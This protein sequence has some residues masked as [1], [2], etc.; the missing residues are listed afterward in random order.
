MPV[1]TIANTKGGAGK[2]TA[3]V[4][5][6][7]ELAKR[8]HVVTLFDSDPQKWMTQWFEAAKPE[9]RISLI[10]HVTPALLDG[11]LREIRAMNEFA[12]IDLPGHR[13]HMTA[14]A[15]GHSD[16]V[17]IPVQGSTM[18][19]IGATNIIDLLATI[20]R[21]TGH[22]IAHSVL[23]TRVNPAVTTRSLMAIKALL[24]ERGVDV[25]ATPVVERSAF[26]EMFDFG[27]STYALDGQ[28]V[29]NLDKAQVNAQ[30]LCDEVKRMLAARTAASA[31]TTWLQRLLR[32][33]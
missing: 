31:K 14:V 33:A 13:D 26:R 1:I 27:K 22:A 5:L 32:A 2:T 19:A 6:A 29:S 20:K 4:L 7:T 24:N 8:G 16:Q 23:L 12:L 21:Q 18:D 17:L 28:K 15:L 25:M 9:G 3:A 10:S 11:H 30:E